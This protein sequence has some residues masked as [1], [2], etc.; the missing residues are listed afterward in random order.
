MQGLW[1]IQT[2]ANP[3]GGAWG[4]GLVV[5]DSLVLVCLACCTT[6]CMIRRSKHWEMLSVLHAGMVLLTAWF[7]FHCIDLI[8]HLER[9]RVAYGYIVVPAL[10]D[11]LRTL[12]DITVVAG[13]RLA[14]RRRRQRAVLSLPLH[15]SLVG[16]A[17]FIALLWFLGLYQ[18]GLNFSL[19]F[20]W[21]G[22]A[23]LQTIR[24]I[25]T[26]RSGF[27]V[28]FAAVNFF[29]AMVL[30]ITLWDDIQETV[31]F[32]HPE[33][34]LPAKQRL[35]QSEPPLVLATLTLLVRSFIELVAVGEI[36]RN[37]RH[38]GNIIVARDVCY[39]LFSAVF[40]ILAA[41]AMPTRSHIDPWEEDEKEGERRD[42]AAREKTRA[43]RE[44]VEERLEKWVEEFEQRVLG[45]LAE[46]TRGGKMA[47]D[48][49]RVVD[50]VWEGLEEKGE[51]DVERMLR[52]EQVVVVDRTK[53]RFKDWRP[54]FKREDSKMAKGREEEDE[55][56]S[57]LHSELRCGRLGAQESLELHDI[58][59]QTYR[60]KTRM[61]DTA[62]LMRYI[63]AAAQPGD[64]RLVLGVTKKYGDG[65]VF[66]VSGKQ[67]RNGTLTMR[68]IALGASMLDYADNLLAARPM[69]PLEC[70][71]QVI[72]RGLSPG[73][74]ALVEKP[75]PGGP[76]LYS[77]W[78]KAVRSVEFM[79]AQKKVLV[80][81]QLD[82]AERVNSKSESASCAAWI[83][84]LCGQRRKTK[85]EEI[86]PQKTTS[87]EVPCTPRSD[88]GYVD[89]LR[90]HPPASEVSNGVADSKDPPAE[91]EFPKEAEEAFMA[92]MQAQQGSVGGLEFV[93]ATEPGLQVDQR[94]EL[95]SGSK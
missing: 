11:I 67:D 82:A 57:R 15:D 13:L 77:L 17:I 25:A 29:A 46:V 62:Q 69:H 45:R 89:P 80:T 54:I 92:R 22:F 18:I 76:S 24:S 49:G 74:R 50:E 65:Q 61:I 78:F 9:A 86:Q 21:L 30:C 39:G 93:I 56:L 81:L 36:D 55:Q 71:D 2:R 19:C 75:V 47:P 87:T 83:P 16:I 53:A 95:S 40:F 41:V 26:A 38:L 52:A 32:K 43:D 14:A 51:G 63:Q 60:F 27:D 73:L 58:D 64:G 10:F 12:S 7:F 33:A 79:D 88:L 1:G 84:W 8:I 35:K 5:W 91:E 48:L 6:Y 4:L 34:T 68:D 59:E 3:H 66:G 72:W 94:I 31:P 70:P 28:A 90:C 42:L 37:P 20:V 23:D 85:S 44:L